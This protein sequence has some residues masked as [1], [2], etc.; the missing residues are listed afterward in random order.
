ELTPDDY[1]DIV[2]DGLFHGLGDWVFTSALYAGATWPEERYE[3]HPKTS[4][5]HDT[6]ARRMRELAPSFV[7]RA[8]DE[9]LAGDP[10]VVGLTTTFMQNVPSLAMATALERRRAD[11]R[12]VLGGGNCDGPM[13]AALH[14]N[15]PVLDYVVSGEGERA[16]VAL[17]DA[18][19]SGPEPDMLRA[20]GGLCWRQGSDSVANPPADESLGMDSVPR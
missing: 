8:A 4:A 20:I 17:L 13:G 2:E 7:E 10:D 12:V 14:R 19:E 3:A 1:S 18:I 6:P 15:F 9:V 5:V 11:P 16:L